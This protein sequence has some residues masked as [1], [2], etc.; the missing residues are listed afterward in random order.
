MIEFFQN[1]WC[2][3]LGWDWS[4]II[5]SI[6]GIATMGIAFAALSVWKK[7]QRSQHVTKLLDSLTDSLHEFVHA[8]YPATQ[9]LQLIRIRMETQVKDPSMDSDIP[10]PGIVTFIEREGKKEAERLMGVLKEAEQPVCRIQSLLVK[11]QV[12]DIQNY[13]MCVDACS[14]ITSQF[15]RLQFVYVMLTGQSLNWKNP[16][17]VEQLE[18]MIAITR[19]NI[20]KHIQENHHAY[21]AFVKGTYEQEY[22]RA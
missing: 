22:R 4:A 15:D 7:Q 2:T 20:E 10:H 12:F 5:Q 17:V 11:G 19:E 8:I 21:L 1:L 16:A 3:V 6:T 13:Q 9:M 18:K 14:H